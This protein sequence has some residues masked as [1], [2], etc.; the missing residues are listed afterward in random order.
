MTVG[1][2]SLGCPKN[3]VDTEVMLGLLIKAGYTVSGDPEDA[4]II[5]VN[6]CGFIE[7]AKQESIDTIL[8]MAAY[9]QN[10]RCSRLLVTGCLSERYADE[11]SRELPEVDGFIGVNAYA[12]IV[13]V[14]ETMQKGRV[15]GWATQPCTLPMNERV[16]S[17][18]GY[19][20]YVKIA[21]GCDNRCSYCAIPSIR[22][23]FRSRAPEDIIEECAALAARGT[24]EITLIAQDTTR[25][26]EDLAE[27]P[28]LPELLAA[29]NDISALHWIR[30]LYCYPERITEQLLET[31]TGLPKVCN[32]LDIPI[33]HIDAEILKKMNR[34]ST[35]E[36]IRSLL[37]RIR[38]MDAGFALRTSLIAGFPG[39]TEEQFN[40]LCDFIQEYPFDHLGAFAFSPEDGTVAAKLPGAV[41]KRIREKR[42]DRLMEIQAAVAQMLNQERIGRV[43]EAVAEGYDQE[44]GLYFGRTYAQAPE[45]DSNVFWHDDRELAPGSFVRIRITASEGYDWMG[46]TADEPGLSP[47]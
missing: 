6:T 41:P 16:L 14:L 21:E 23:R 30:V 38:R 15:T 19:T 26:G 5:I 39:E 4:D 13:P 9:K 33:Q 8:E 35:P 7:D 34:R 31:I 43:Y 44:S 45:I 18:P 36:Q 28:L 10:G 42:R 17:T 2:V 24:R 29:L 1:V 27:K 11:L 40:R 37:S 25:Y 32:Y 47:E 3:R 20:A 12:D 22:G 46:E